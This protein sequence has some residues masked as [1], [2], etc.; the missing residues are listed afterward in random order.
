MHIQSF[1]L[2][3]SLVT[4]LSLVTILV[5]MVGPMPVLASHTSNPSN[6]TLVG[7]LQSELGC[8]DDWD[9]G[10][11]ATYLNY[12]AADDV[13][14]STFTVPAGSYEY[15]AALNNGWDEN[16]GANAVPGGGNISLNGD[17]SSVKFYYDHKSH[18]ITS[19]KTSVI[20]VAPG[21]FQSELGCPGDWSPDCLRSWL[22]DIDGDGIYT[23]VTTAL[24]V[25]NYE[26]KVALNEGW[27]LNYGE[28]GVQ[29]GANL[30]FAVNAPDST[31][32][33]SYNATTH[34]L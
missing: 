17:G 26:G 20:A 11:S 10:C 2:L 3:R 29:N 24:P 32:T 33:F 30:A 25:G 8:G 27:D 15:K 31:V 21:S 7:S 34:V 6:V 1:R 14:Q 18:W 16:Y 22:Q 12:D 19:N 13:W 23:F 4:V 9:P 5:G 28:G